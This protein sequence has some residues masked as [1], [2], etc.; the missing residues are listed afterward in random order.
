MVWCDLWHSIRGS[1][2]KGSRHGSS[3][4]CGKCVKT[5]HEPRVVDSN[6][7]SAITDIRH[8][9]VRDRFDLKAL[10][11]AATSGG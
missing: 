11:E 8:A 9:Q 1:D 10:N 7:T 6:P 3:D 5:T 4:L 2:N